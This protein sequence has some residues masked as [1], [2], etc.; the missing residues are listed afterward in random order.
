MYDP[1]LVF[2]LWMIKKSLFPKKYRY[3]FMN[4]LIYCIR[5]KITLYICRF[6]TYREILAIE[7]LA[8][9]LNIKI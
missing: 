2:E 3:V 6:Q 9:F 4:Y 8:F 1:T 7:F 5:Y